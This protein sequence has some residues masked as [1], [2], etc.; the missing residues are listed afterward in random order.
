MTFLPHR[1]NQNW[2]R[3]KRRYG[4]RLPYTFARKSPWLK[5]SPLWI[6]K[7]GNPVFLSKLLPC[8][9]GSLLPVLLKLWAGSPKSDHRGQEHMKTF[10]RKQRFSF[11]NWDTVLF[12]FRDHRNLEW[13]NC[14]GSSNLSSREQMSCCSVFIQ[15]FSNFTWRLQWGFSP[16]SGQPICAPSQY[17]TSVVVIL[18]G[19]G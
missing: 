17:C 4:V 1:H 16:P 15:F 2:F 7:L 13:T 19:K 9:K 11:F 14:I 5:V 12:L 6:E 18:E 3:R 10:L 8:S